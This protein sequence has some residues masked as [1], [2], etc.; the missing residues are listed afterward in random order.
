MSSSSTAFPIGPITADEHPAFERTTALAF[1]ES[2]SDE[3]IANYGSII[4]LD[5]TLAAR[6]GDLIVGT[7]I[8]LAF[9]LMLPYSLAVPCAGVTSVGVRP[10]HRR[11][12]VLASL[13]R[14]QLDDFRDRGETWAALYASE[15]TIYGR[16][17]YG[18][19][20]RSIDIAIDRQWT[21]LERPLAPATVE[22]VDAAEARRRLPAI[23]EAVRGETPGM[24]SRPEELWRQRVE[25]DPESDR[26]GASERYLAVI[27]DSAY[28]MYRVKKDWRDADPTS[29]VRVE[30]LL[31]TDADTGRRLWDYLFGIDMM[32]RI[33]ATQRPIDDL[34]PWWLVHRDRLRISESAAFFARLVD[35]GGA[36]SQRGTRAAAGIVVDVIDGFCPWNTRR[37]HLEGDGHTLRCTETHDSADVR[38]D[39]RELASLSLGG[40]SATQ[41]QRAG[42]IEEDTAGAAGCLDALLATDRPPW[43]PFIF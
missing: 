37:W 34:L 38:M 28:A 31:A 1:S 7:A 4:D 39:A 17:G 40:V 32:T 33:S 6:D 20:S 21:A 22:L 30:E 36:L 8:D 26:G 10:T 42:L 15:S 11:R 23:Y 16:F 19:A 12:G 24:L 27:G 35:V 18:L 5:R 9:T 14:R 29:T 3:Q 2:L 13:M 43:N 25:W 41:L